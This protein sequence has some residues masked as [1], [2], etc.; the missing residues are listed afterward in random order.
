M[1]ELAWLLLALPAAGALITLFFGR[2]LG[3][4]AVGWIAS[5]VVAAAFLVGVGVL[6]ALMGLAAEQRA[7]TVHLWNWITIGEF[8]IPAALL[9]DPLSVTMTLIVTGVGALI[10]FY[11]I[12]YMEHDERFQRFFFY[13][14]FFIFAMLILVLSNNF[15]GMFVGWEGV[16]LASFL[17]I[18]FWFDRRDDSYGYY[19]DAGKKA[20]LV[21]RVGDFGMIVAMLAIWSALGSLTFVE[22]FEQAEHGALTVGLANFICL[23]L[24]LA[25][26][27]KSA[28]I[29]LYVWLP[30]AM[31]GPTPVSALIHAATMVT[32]GIYMI[33]RTN[34]LWHIAEQA[35]MVAAWAGA[36][37]ALFAATIALVQVDL[38][39][40]LAYSTISQLGYMMLG[41]GVGAYGA[42]IFHLTT[43]AF[44][45]ALLFLAAGSVMHALNGELDIRKMG[46]L[47]HK[48]PTTFWTFLI[49]AA[50]LAGIPFITAGYWSKDAILLGA[51][52]GNHWILY[53]VGLATALLTAIYS[54][55]ALFVPFFGEPRDRHLYDHAHESPPL[56]TTPLWVLAVLS[57]V[58]GF[59][60]LPLILTLEHWLEPALGIHEEPSL[61][62][63]LLALTLSAVVAVFGVLLARALYLTREPWAGRAAES[64]RGLEPA[65]QQKWYVDDF[66]W[67]YIVLPLRKLAQWSAQVFDQRVIDGLIN[68]VADAS[69]RIGERVRRL[70]TGAI[71]T[72]AL[73][74]LIGVAALVAFFVFSA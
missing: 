23:M 70:E 14:N 22:V 2:S 34:V 67:N 16:G 36:L 62:L 12:S 52:A 56:M 18:G 4:R 28:Q 72:Y 27:G 29:P 66:Y 58:G 53:V 38:K 41:V 37:T 55:R 5:G 60:N 69:I 10:H 21:N 20:F 65:A 47:R 44:F 51:L 40:I 1:I 25:A 33:A 43:H 50:A 35:A 24:L 49:G 19:A 26:T 48:M 63:E 71:P 61:T 8:Q 45:K 39:K 3:N 31:A 6:A 68:G 15:L 9:I 7:V 64:V 73:S 32:A 30:D 74:I 42:A 17:L 13:L 11:S 59:I 57:I 46:G 54:F